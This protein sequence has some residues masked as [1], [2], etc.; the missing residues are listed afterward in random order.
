MLARII[1]STYP[2]REEA[3]KAAKEAISKRLAACVN[4]VEVNSIYTWKGNIEDVKEFLAIYKTTHA[5]AA[6]LQSFIEKSHSY[7][8]PEVVTLNPTK[9]SKKY[10][11]WLI[12]STK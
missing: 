9:V 4:I 7:D 6:K 10:M 12:D 5:K 2:S 1:L 8:V 11:A 3:R